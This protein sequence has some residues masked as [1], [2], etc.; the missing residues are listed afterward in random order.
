MANFTITPNMSLILPIPGQDPGPDY[1]NNQYS[2]GLILDGHNHSPGSGVQITPSGLNINADLPINGNNLTFVKTV[3]FQSQSSS[4]AGASP[5]LGCIYVAGN[6]LYY[7]DESG[8]VVPITKTGS[9]NAGAGSITGLPSGTASASY[10]SG[11]ETFVWQS[12]T[13]TPANLDAGSVVI[14]DVS[15]NSHGVTLSA[16]SA[17]ASDLTLILPSTLPS[18][19]SIATIDT[20]GNISTFPASNPSTNSFVTVSSAGTLGTLTRAP[21]IIVSSSSGAFTGT[22]QVTN[23]QV[24]ITTN[25]GPVKVGFSPAPYDNVHA[26]SI[27]GTLTGDQASALFQLYFGSPATTVI[28]EIQITSLPF[29]VGGTTL[30][31]GPSNLDFVDF[32]VSGTPGTYTY[33]L[34]LE[35]SFGGFVNYVVMY[36]YE[37]R[38]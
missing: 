23:M 28:N 34:F 4:L 29:G 13:N 15:A 11:T 26:S 14:R 32:S 36:A 31:I 18:V 21:N 24:T 19:T 6:E 38:F 25:G 1:G 16:P 30:N 17:L 3:N 27:G 35:N 33:S 22:G 37:I 2:S 12:A 9:V 5:N 10:N 8:N 7:N 20:S